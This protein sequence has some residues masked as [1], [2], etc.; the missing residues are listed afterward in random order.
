MIRLNK[1]LLLLLTVILISA[2][3]GCKK[4][5]EKLKGTWTRMGDFPGGKRSYAVSFVIG[6]YGYLCTGM[7]DYNRLHDVW[8]YD[9]A[10]DSWTER[11][12][13]PGIERTGAVAFSIGNK[14]YLGLGYDGANYLNDFWEYEPSTDTWTQKAS[15]PGSARYGAVG[16]GLD[17]KGF[18]GCGYD[19]HYLNDFYKYDPANNTWNEI[20]SPGY[21]RT[22]SSFFVYANHGYVLGGEKDGSMV[23][24]FKRLNPNDIQYTWTQLNYLKNSTKSSFDDK[25]TDLAR[26]EFNVFL[27]GDKAYAALGRANGIYLKTTWEYDIAED[28][29]YMVAPF[30]STPRFSATGFSIG[31]AGYVVGGSL[32]SETTNVW[33]KCNEVWKFVP[34]SEN[35]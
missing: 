9:P 4:G 11:S 5:E 19:D 14:G 7:D 24:E 16:F 32:K 27:I 20:M 17:G 15:F 31:S 26:T 35:E 30:P 34:E 18:L 13:F 22:N 23:S 2:F 1:H 25:Y 33:G 3:P 8:R 28:L 21:K 10:G 29:W 6:Q 12:P